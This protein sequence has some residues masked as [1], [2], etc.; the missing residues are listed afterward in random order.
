MPESL[1]NT[2]RDLTREGRA[3]DAATAAI[4]GLGPQ[5][6][7][8]LRS[9]LRDEEAARDAFSQFAENLWKGLPALRDDASLRGW[10]FRLAFNAALNLRD[11]AWRRRGR[12]LL[13]GEASQLA[14]EVRTKTVVRVERQRQALDTLRDALSIEDRSL[15]ALRIDQELS[16]AEIADAFAAE[17]KPVEPV[18][19]MKRFERLK[20]RLGRLARER[21][22]L[23]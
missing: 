7:R 6:L 3:A 17:G 1:E 9:L 10:A 8:Y 18:T 14:E 21:G 19:L 20:E 5:V 22:L 13:T 2:V 11:E 15:L 4:R 12:R 16:W 23:E